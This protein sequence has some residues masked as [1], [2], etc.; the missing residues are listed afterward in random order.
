MNKPPRR[1]IATPVERDGWHVIAAEHDAPL[2]VEQ[3]AVVLMKRVAPR[4]D[5][6][7]EAQPGRTIYLA[8]LEGTLV[9]GNQRLSAPGRLILRGGELRITSEAGAT[10]VM[11][12]VALTP[13]AQSSL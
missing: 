6:S 12:D 2:V 1:A 4:S 10:V 3:D 9:A 8:A 5:V 7:V 13:P 11:V